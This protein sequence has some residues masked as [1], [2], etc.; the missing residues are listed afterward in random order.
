[1]QPGAPVIHDEPD[2]VG[3][4][5]AGRNIAVKIHASLRRRGAG[6]GRGR[7]RL[8]AHY[9]VHQVQQASI[10]PHIVVTYWDEDERMVIRTSTQ[11]PFHVRRMIAPLIGLPVKRIR[12]IKP[13]IGGGFGGK[14]EML[15]EDLVRPSDHR[16]RA[17]GALRVQ[18]RAGV[19]QR[20]LAPP[21]D[22]SPTA[23]ASPRW[24]ADTRWTCTCLQHRRLWH[25]RADRVQRVRVARAGHLSLPQHAVHCRGRLHQP[26]DAGRV[27]RLRRAAGR[28]RAGKPDGGDR[29]GAGLDPVEFR[30][31]NCGA[32]RRP[33][34][35]HARRWARAKETVEPAS[36]AEL[37]A[38]AVRGQGAAAIAW[39][40]K[41]PGLARDPAQPHIRRGLGWPSAC[42]APPSPGWTW[43]RPASR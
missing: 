35:D 36:G 1:M 41:R 13:R 5:D 27:P 3:I 7:S 40:R 39:D 19:H 31:K 2:A 26:P 18:P 11:V 21:D 37:R 32:L 8:R 24:H 10:E 38:G 6:A 4:A 43:A 12:V 25:P 20:P 33:A 15:I 17:A 28:V 42:T 29:R 34:A 9:H 23:P 30:L 22:R 14:Q 16:H